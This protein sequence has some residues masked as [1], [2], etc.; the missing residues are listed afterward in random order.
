M[1]PST[2]WE[3]RSK[4]L[5]ADKLKIRVENRDYLMQNLF[6]QLKQGERNIYVVNAADQK[7]SA[8]PGD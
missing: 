4:T 8:S 3:W 1:R 5:V 6:R 2:N 7:R